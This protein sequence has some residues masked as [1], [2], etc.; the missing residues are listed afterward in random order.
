MR[1]KLAP[2]RKAPGGGVH[3][4][5]GNKKVRSR[6]SP[7]T[8]AALCGAAAALERPSSADPL[9]SSASSCALF[10]FGRRTTIR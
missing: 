2:L 4:V 9:V 3:K 6:G 10:G 7:L 5:V 8:S 1:D